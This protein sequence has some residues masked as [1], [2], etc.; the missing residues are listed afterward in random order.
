MDRIE[1]RQNARNKLNILKKDII[2]HREK[3]H[4]SVQGATLMYHETLQHWHSTICNVLLDLDIDELPKYNPSLE[5]R[6]LNQRIES[7]EKYRRKDV[8]MGI[9]YEH[10]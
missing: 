2:K 6:D 1:A 5:I 3:T 7:L 10:E 4:R 9:L 8:E